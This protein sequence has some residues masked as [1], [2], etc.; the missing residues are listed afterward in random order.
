MTA[1]AYPIPHITWSSSKTLDSL[2]TIACCIVVLSHVY[3]FVTGNLNNPLNE[4]IS[5]LAVALFFFISGWVNTHSVLRTTTKNF[6]LKRLKRIYPTYLKAFVLGLG[7]ALIFGVYNHHYLLNAVFL[8]PLVGTIP[9]NAPLWS[10]SYEVYLYLL[11]P[12]M[13]RGSTFTTVLG[14]LLA[15]LVF[16]I[17]GKYLLLYA[18]AAGVICFYCGVQLPRFDFFARYGRYTYEVYVYHYLVLFTLWGI[19]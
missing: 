1:T 16:F 14:W 2:R 8:N 3:E 12:L 7:L 5:Y 18:F 4:W 13:L 9:T 15:C 11:L 10:L 19:F 17:A 6:Y